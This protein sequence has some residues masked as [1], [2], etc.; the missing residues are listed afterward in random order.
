MKDTIH[1]FHVSDLSDTDWLKYKLEKGICDLE[2]FIDSIQVQTVC[3]LMDPTDYSKWDICEI[4]NNEMLTGAAL[5][6]L[7]TRKLL[8]MNI[9]DL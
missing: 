1:I 5:L 6:K 2:S 8:I 9:K 3:C 7:Q 4:R